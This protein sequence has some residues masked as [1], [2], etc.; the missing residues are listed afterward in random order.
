VT[1]NEYDPAVVAVPLS[2]P[3]LNVA[4]GGAVPLKV[5]VYGGVPPVAAN[6]MPIDEP[7]ATLLKP[8]VVMARVAGTMVT[9]MVADALLFAESDAVT[10]KEKEPAT[11]G[12]PCNWP[13][14][15]TCKP[16]GIVP[17]VVNV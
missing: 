11:V 14:F 12:V 13:L 8:A 4:P 3:E 10:P 17:V 9:E 7:T 15:D 2:V 16:G 6:V 1:V 5:N